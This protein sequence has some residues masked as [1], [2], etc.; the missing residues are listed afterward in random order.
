MKFIFN[1]DQPIYLQ[2]V[3]QLRIYIISG[4]ISPGEKLPTVRELAAQARANPNTVQRALNILEDEGI[5]LTERTNG[6][7]VTSDTRLI[8]KIRHRLATDNVS[9]YFAAMSALGFTQEDAIKFLIK[10][11]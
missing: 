9:K 1:N 10:E 8:R 7:Y 5:I 11:E 2:I 4:K 3:E 6:K